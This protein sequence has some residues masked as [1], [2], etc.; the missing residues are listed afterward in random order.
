MNAITGKPKV[1]TLAEEIE[2]LRAKLEAAM[3]DRTGHSISEAVHRARAAA[4]DM[5]SST[6]DMASTVAAS[7]RDAASSV[8]SNTREMAGN[9]AAVTQREAEA[10]AGQVRAHPFLSVAIA[11]SVG[12]LA[13]L[14]IGGSARRD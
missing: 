10:A 12:C 4:A 9:V 8:A 7:T 14:L 11:A 5:A 6:R 13:G 3:T 1:E 2:A